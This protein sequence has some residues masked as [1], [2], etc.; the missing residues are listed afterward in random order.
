M[1]Y[2]VRIA[3]SPASLI[4]AKEFLGWEF[5]FGVDVLVASG[6]GMRLGG[7]SYYLPWLA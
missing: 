7:E 5:F 2:L 4:F 6:M 3:T 1:C